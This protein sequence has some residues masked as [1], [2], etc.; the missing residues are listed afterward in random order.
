MILSCTTRLIYKGKV[1]MKILHLSYKDTQEGAAIAAERL[2][3][4]LII[5][6]VDS[7]M[8]VQ[9]KVSDYPFVSS[10]GESRFD[11]VKSMVRIGF[12][13]LIN[14]ILIND[15]NEYFTLPFLGSKVSSCDL[16]EEADLIHLHWINRGFISL[17]TMKSLS[18]YNKPIVWTLHDSWAFTGGCHM[19]GTCDKYLNGC[20]NC[21]YMVVKRMSN[22]QIKR[23]IKIYNDLNLN[24]IA[25]SN[26]MKERATN[27]FLF[28][29]TP[30]SVI[31]NCVDTSIFKPIDKK[32]AKNFLNVSTDKTVILFYMTKN[33]RKG[34][35]YINKVLSKINKEND[36]EFIAF[37]SSSIYSDIFDSKNIKCYGKI[38]DTYT[39]SLLYNAADIYI[40]PALEEPFGQTY[41]EAMACGTP[42]VGFNYSGPRDII[43]HCQNGYLAEYLNVDDLIKGIEYCKEHRA[44]LSK[45]AIEKVNNR[46]SYEKVA[47]QHIN[48]YSSLIKRG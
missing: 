34:N 26:W 47:I 45:H 4:A 23:K 13:L 9:S 42:C 48:L 18:K 5:N 31:P 27:S 38:S 35:S 8:L 33:I 40:S 30:V 14:K 15:M 39:L 17:T 6:N 28:K 29:N 3:R 12:D 25:P 36:Y 21:D 44:E 7:R 46:Y 16:V 10:I 41:I 2:C 20:N 22:T 19:T 32:N 1:N 24:I 11:K 43:D 37:G